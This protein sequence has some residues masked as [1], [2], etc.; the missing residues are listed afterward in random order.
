MVLDSRGESGNVGDIPRGDRAAINYIDLA[1]GSEAGGGDI[2][3][4]DNVIVYEGYSSSTAIYEGLGSD[5][6]SIK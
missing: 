1:G 3:L 5:R 4:A 6:L 2:L